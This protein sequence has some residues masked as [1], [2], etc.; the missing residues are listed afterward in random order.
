VLKENEDPHWCL[1]ISSDGQYLATGSGDNGIYIWDM[2]KDEV[3]KKLYG[4]TNSIES[5]QFSP[6]NQYLIAGSDDGTCTLWK[7]K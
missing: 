4:H 5:V 3:I 6:N 2:E 7:L 1:A